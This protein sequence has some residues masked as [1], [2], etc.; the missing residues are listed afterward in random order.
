MHPEVLKALANAADYIKDLS[1]EGFLEEYKITNLHQLLFLEILSMIHANKHIKKCKNCGVY[2]IVPNTKVE[3]CN[4]IA[5]GEEKTCQV[6]GPTRTFE[7]KLETDY[8]LKI[9]K[10]AYNTHFARK[11]R[12]SGAMKH[13]QFDIWVTEAK[14][15]LEKVRAGGMAIQDFEKWLK[16]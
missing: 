16:K 2:F 11:Q 4:R 15:R 7:R 13:D 10:R 14:E 6:I 8:P 3:Y 1:K 5:P 12:V 9:Y